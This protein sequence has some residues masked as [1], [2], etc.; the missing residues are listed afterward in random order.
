MKKAKKQKQ[1]ETEDLCMVGDTVWI[2]LENKHKDKPFKDLITK[3]DTITKI[4][5]QHT[6]ELKEN[7]IWSKRSVVKGN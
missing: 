4:I 2:E 1:I 6:A 3:K 5:D 7:A